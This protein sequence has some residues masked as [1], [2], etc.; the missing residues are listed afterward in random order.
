MTFQEWLVENN[1]C[2]D[3]RAWVGRK[4]LKKAWT[5]CQNPEWMEWLLDASESPIR[6][7]YEAKRAPILAEYVAKHLGLLRTYCPEIDLG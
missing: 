2:E 3:A 1:A 4:G 5:T 6:D 7:E